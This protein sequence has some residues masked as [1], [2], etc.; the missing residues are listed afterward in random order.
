MTNCEGNFVPP[1]LFFV[2]MVDVVLLVVQVF[3]FIKKV[4]II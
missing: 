4:G 1:R 2:F 3:F